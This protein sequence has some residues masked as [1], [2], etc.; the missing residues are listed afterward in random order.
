MKNV[1]KKESSAPIAIQSERLN[2]KSMLAKNLNYFGNV[3]DCDLQPVVQLVGNTSYEGLDC[4]GYNP[5]TENMEA[6]FSI[7]RS[8]GY[9]GNLCGN[10]SFEY[11]RFYLDFN[12]GAG[13][14]D[15]GVTRVNVHDIPD[16]K[17]CE[18]QSIF[19]LNYVATL[20]KKTSKFSFCSA[21]ILPTLRA[22]LSWNNEPPQ[23]SPNWQPVWGDV[24]DCEIQLKPFFFKFPDQ[25]VLQYEL[26]K[27]LELAVTAP[28]LSAQQISEISGID[29]KGFNPQ[30]E[31]PA[32]PE[33]VA[34]SLKLKIPE[35][36]FAFSAIQEMTDEPESESSAFTAKTLEN[37]KIN[38]S[39]LIDTFNNF[40]VLDNSKAN[41]N[42]EEL[43]CL[44]LNYHTE[45]LVATIKIKEN[46]GY[47]GNLCE[48]GSKEYVAFWIDWE[49]KCEWQYLDTVVLS[50]HD[51]DVGDHLCYSV[52]LPLDAAL[53]KKLCSNPNVVRVRG[54]LSWNRRPSTTDPN[55]LEFYGNRI[56]THVQIKPGVPVDGVAPLFTIIGG[57]DVDHV[58]DIDG[59]TRSGAFFAFN[60]NGVPSAAPFGG[61]IVLNGPSF[62]GHRYRI[63]V[64][65][66]SDGTVSYPQDS[67]TVVGHLTSAPWVQ[68]SNQ[69]V[70]TDGYYPFLP[71]SKNTLN[72]LSRFTP[73]NNDLLQVEI[74]V[75]GM[76]G[77]FGKVIQMDNIKPDIQLQIN[78]G[79]DCTHYKKG[80]TITGHFYV[81]D[82][83]IYR[84]GLGNTWTGAIN[85]NSNTPPL[86][87]S[88]FSIPTQ[89]DAH[90]C[91][92]I[93]LKAE[94]KTIVDSQSVGFEVSERYNVCLQDE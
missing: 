24:A 47:G 19:P 89:P 88:P 43:E 54:V 52:S 21:P 94:D 46:L 29:I 17:D 55:K 65:N 77:S 10:G 90:P 92:S 3:P 23:D 60:G 67:F 27:Y 79:G 14:I 37:A 76:A 74:E 2:F 68:Y 71:H 73:G 9:G 41:V 39:E 30:P 61:K 13:F 36:R 4:I 72:V 64:T 11:V 25:P 66:L 26:S 82:K 12:D 35:S 57:I 85:G 45:S 70:G 86:P 69:G 16:A 59:L 32:F 20:K 87:G 93:S 62:P 78:D 22:I 50:V 31:P 48:D 58:S 81:F 63:K 84:W 51:I 34:K 83:H 6:T 8:S 18:N 38:I 5:D 75:K 7:K 56:D 49:D 91:G 42:Y 44:G 33:L 80:D 53:F 28:D 15:Q 40:E 1:S